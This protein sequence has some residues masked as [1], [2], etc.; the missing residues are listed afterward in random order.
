MAKAYPVSNYREYSP[1][2]N[3]YGAKISEHS[4]T[5]FPTVIADQET[6]KFRGQ[7]RARFGKGPTARLELELGAY[8]GET[9]NHLARTN[10]EA[11]HLGIEWKYKQ[12]FLAGKRRATRASRT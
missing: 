4:A 10:P 7:W 1:T 8:H 12:C 2:R 5:G 9:S 3:P 11:V 6:E